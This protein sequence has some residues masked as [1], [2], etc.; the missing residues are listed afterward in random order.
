MAA[1]ILYRFHSMVFL[2]PESLVAVNAVMFDR[3]LIDMM[4]DRNLTDNMLGRHLID[5]MLDRH[6]MSNMLNFMVLTLSVLKGSFLSHAIAE[7]RMV[8]V[9]MVGHMSRLIVM[10]MMGRLIGVVMTVTE[11]GVPI[12]S[13]FVAIMVTASS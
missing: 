12:F 1:M 10:T 8:N 5:T 2:R 9:M 7:Y 4:L 13:V 6:L 11:V 3:Y